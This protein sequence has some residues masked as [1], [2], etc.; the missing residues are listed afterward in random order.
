MPVLP[1]IYGGAAALGALG[2]G[3]AA[4]NR[5]D[6]EA[7]APQ[8]ATPAYDV[9]NNPS[10]ARGA[11]LSGRSP[12]MALPPPPAPPLCSP[13]RRGNAGGGGDADD[14]DDDDGDARRTQR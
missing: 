3:R 9:S 2:A 14:D 10:L 6:D 8:S 13:R 12:R 4:L 11:A 7:E 1:L 5:R